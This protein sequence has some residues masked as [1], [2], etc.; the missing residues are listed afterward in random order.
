V[1]VQGDRREK[2]A[3]HTRRNNAWIIPIS[4]AGNEHKIQEASWGPD[5]VIHIYNSA[6][7]R[8]R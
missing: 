7:G 5:I 3:K 1:G 6:I 8:R 4:Q 2:G